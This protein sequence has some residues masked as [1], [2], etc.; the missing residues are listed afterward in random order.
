MKHLCNVIIKNKEWVDNR[1]KEIVEARSNIKKYFNNDN[2]MLM[3]IKRTT[4]F[5]SSIM[6]QELNEYKDLNDIG[7]N[8]KLTSSM[9]SVILIEVNKHMELNVDIRSFLEMEKVI[10][11]SYNEIGKQFISDS[12]TKEE[13]FKFIAKFFDAFEIEM[14]VEIAK[15]SERKALDKIKSSD[16][17]MMINNIEEYKK[18]KDILLQSEIRFE[19]LTETT[20]SAIFIN[21]GLYFTYV[22][23]A[24]ERLT[25]YSAEELYS[26]TMLD[27][28][29]KQYIDTINKCTMTDEDDNTNEARYEV[30][31][32]TKDG[33]KKWVD[34]SVGAVFLDE[35]KQLIIS[36]FDISK[37]KIMEHEIIES[38]RQ[39]Q[40]LVELLPDAIYVVSEN[41]VILANQAGLEMLGIDSL[42]GAQE[43][44]VEDFFHSYVDSVPI[45][46]ESVNNAEFP[47]NYPYVEQKFIRKCDGKPIDVEI[48]AIGVH[49]GCKDAIMMYCRDILERRRV[50]ELCRSADENKRLLHEAVEYDKLKTEFFSNISHELKTPINVLLGTIQLSEYFYNNHLVK[51]NMVKMEKY[52]GIMKQNCFRLIRLVNNLI[53]ITKIDSGYLKISFKN[54]N[55]VSVIEDITLSVAE[56]IENKGVNLVFDTDVEEK[57]MACDSDKIERIIL[58]LLSNAIKYTDAGGSIFVNLYDMNDNIIIC[59]RD[60]GIGIPEDKQKLIFERFV[61]VDKSLS[62]NRE[63]SGI[64]LS[65]VK[66]LVDMHKGS[67]WVKSVC[68]KGSS[69]YIKLPVFKIQEEK[70]SC[71]IESFIKPKKIETIQIEFSDIY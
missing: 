60:T 63:G 20:D 11:K 41:R 62:R 39:Y 8:M 37:R 15:F 29:E 1:C 17:N 65:L 5:I 33:D 70:D 36:A 24:A 43:K 55:I 44:N 40:Q 9:M 18:M 58:N 42:K 48:S 34:V 69:F 71:E 7:N 67:I 38:K 10:R 3:S 64:G 49:Y 52:N 56:Y 59:V 22:N 45:T 32:I 12:N 23:P 51:E 19:K 47:I 57:Y 50:Y 28:V 25:G 13:Y 68:G 14:S 4:S 54:C 26:M 61:Q 46:Q 53:D 66:S 2:N 27:I 16:S 31:I 30:I 6:I 35:K 21:D